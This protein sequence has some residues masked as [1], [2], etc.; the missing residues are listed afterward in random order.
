V[1]ALRPPVLTGLTGEAGTSTLAAALHARDTG[2]TGD[3]PVGADVLVCRPT[4][5]ALRQAAAVVCTPPDGLRP[6][7]AVTLEPAGPGGGTLARLSALE[8]RFAAV[9]A[10][11]HVPEWRASTDPREEAARV[12]AQPVERLPRPLR[13]YAVALRHLVNAV[14][15]SGLL[16]RAAPPSVTVPRS[17][18]PW[19]GLRPVPRPAPPRPV[20]LHAPPRTVPIPLA[21]RPGALVSRPRATEPDDEMLEAEATGA[22]A[23]AGRAG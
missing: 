15:G 2:R 4:E 14:V 3:R 7:L 19:W 16:T 22:V 5:A 20:L 11:P 9:V 10:L 13:A 1:S 21:G 12:L 17:S 6:V 18:E 8:P 23:V